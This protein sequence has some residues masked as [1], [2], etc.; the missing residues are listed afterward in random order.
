MK[1]NKEEGPT[2]I[3]QKID[4]LISLGFDYNLNDGG[5]WLIS[6]LEQNHDIDDENF[7]LWLIIREMGNTFIV[8]MNLE[9]FG[10]NISTIRYGDFFFYHRISDILLELHRISSG[11]ITFKVIDEFEPIYNFDNKIINHDFK[12]VINKPNG[13]TMYNCKYEI[14]GQLFDFEYHFNTYESTVLNPDFVDELC[15]KLDHLFLENNINYLSE[16]FITFFQL[17]QHSQEALNET[18][19]LNK[20]LI[21]KYRK[22]EFQKKQEKIL[23][24]KIRI[25]RERNDSFLQGLVDTRFATKEEINTLI[26][27]KNQK[28][29]DITIS[30]IMSAGILGLIIWAL[31]TEI[32]NI[33][34]IQLFLWFFF[35]L[36]ICFAFFVLYESKIWLINRDLDEKQI[37]RLR[38]TVSRVY[39]IK[40][41]T[42]I[43]LKKSL[44][45]KNLFFDGF[46]YVHKGD[47]VI[48]NVF[49]QSRFFIE[50][51]GV[52]K[53]K[54]NQ[55]KSQSSNIVIVIDNCPA[56][57]AMLRETDFVCPECG[58][59]FK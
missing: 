30:T 27:Y 18:V 36:T 7:P 23:N 54:S 41:K 42:Y 26:N 22:T 40:G 46:L 58:L 52:N 56:C 55:T 16:E 38:G 25:E 3:D 17:P 15:G 44:G 49:Q 4:Y 53:P 24:D 32:L 31:N 9:K 43:R 48:L 19:F 33:L 5:E 29:T 57:S 1:L 13:I 28:L 8:D 35:V 12:D 50:L 21:K 6:Y 37:E 47:E 45:I 2:H 39:K 14:C 20:D 34:P 59:S 51:G 11:A 10:K